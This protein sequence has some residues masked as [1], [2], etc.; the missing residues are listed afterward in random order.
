MA[1]SGSIDFSATRDDIITESLELLGVLGEGEAANTDQLTSCARSLNMLVKT[2]QAEGLNLFAMQQAYLFLEVDTSSY[3]LPGAHWT[4]SFSETTLAADAALG[5]STIT[6]ASAAN[7]SDADF[8]G[9]YQDGTM[10]WTTVN[11]AP[12]GAVVTLTDVL[13]AAASSGAVVYSYTTAATRPMALLEAVV[14]QFNSTDLPIE[15]VSRQEY[16]YQPL[17]TT[18]GRVVEIYYDP[19]VAAGRLYVWPE[20]DDPRN[21]LKINVQRTL[22]DLDDAADDVDFPQEWFLPLAYNL[23]MALIPKYGTDKQRAAQIGSLATHWYDM[24]LG[25]DREQVSVMFAPHDRY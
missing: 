21:Y 6:V 5:A 7:I 14:H 1:T 11:G 12:A 17:K 15:I 25:F 9:I 13:T 22:D 2:W 4:T 18:D 8:I 20:S 24:A 16:H 3:L 10:L 23:A 19:Q